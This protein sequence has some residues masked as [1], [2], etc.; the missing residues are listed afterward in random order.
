MADEISGSGLGRYQR[1][2]A[3]SGSSSLPSGFIEVQVSVAA[4]AA[5]VLA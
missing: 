5:L 3:M 2:S 1:T 4:E